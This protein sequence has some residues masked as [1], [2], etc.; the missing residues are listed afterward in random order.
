MPEESPDLLINGR[1]L[2]QALTGVQRYATELVLAM[3]EML[4]SGVIGAPD[5]VITLVL[6][7]NAQCELPLRYIRTARVGRLQGQLW[8]QIELARY[9]PRVLL[10]NL[11]NLGPLVRRRQTVTIHDAS[12]YAAPESY[13]LGFRTWYRIAYAVLMRRARA[14]ITVSHFSRQELARYTGTPGDRFRVVYSGAEHL[15]KLEPDRRVLHKNGLTERPFVL[16]VSSLA[17]HKNFRLVSR[18]LA[19]IPAEQR[20]FDMVIAGAPNARVFGG[21]GGRELA[22]VRQIGYVSDAEL[23]ALYRHAACFI[24][25][26]LYEGFGLPPLEA[27]H[28]GCPVVAARSGAIPEICADAAAYFDP[29]DPEDLARQMLRVTSDASFAGAL[30]TRGHL[31]AADFTWDRCALATYDVLAGARSA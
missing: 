31:R 2:S 11:C 20:T 27:M 19:R 16:A 14:L 13:S 12:I 1:F 10:V 24:Y 18:A 6:P 17:P 5:S 23:A 8:E 4:A 26:S 15:G 21:G 30:S 22:G 25:P 3:D 7:S 29:L 28:A 9:R